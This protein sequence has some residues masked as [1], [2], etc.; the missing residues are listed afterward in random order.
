[1]GT[2]LP[3]LVEPVQEPETQA[4]LPV[5]PEVPVVVVVHIQFQ[6][7]PAA[8]AFPAKEMRA[9]RT[10]RQHPVFPQAAVAARG[11]LV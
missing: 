4:T 10:E 5:I 9:D 7:C 11:L 3:L 2:L 1:L 6:F 8:L